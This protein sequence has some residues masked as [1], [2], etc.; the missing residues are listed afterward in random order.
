MSSV[1]TEK[2]IL[3]GILHVPEFQSKVYPHL[4]KELFE[5]DEVGQTFDL[6]K[7]YYDKFESLP[8]KE[9]L[10]VELENHKGL[11]EEGF[12]N[13]CSLLTHIYSEPVV[14]GIRKQN[15]DW[16]LKTSEKHLLQRSCFNAV[17]EA[18]NVVDGKD[19]KRSLES[20]P[21]LLK[22]AV[23]VS[24]DTEIGHDYIEDFM[25]RYEFYH[26][27]QERIPF[28][29]SM[30]NHVTGGG[31][32][33][34]AIYI[35][36]ASTGVGKS[37]FLTD[38]ASYLLT[39]G[40]N[41][42]YVTLEMA[43]FRL[44]ERVDAKLFDMTINDLPSLDLDGFQNKIQQLKEKK[45]GKIIFKEYPTGS[46]NAN[47][48]E[49]LLT[50]LKNKKNF[51]PDVLMVDYLNLMNSYRAPSG[52]NSYTV[53]KLVTEEL[54]GLAMKHNCLLCSPIQGNRSTQGS[55]E[56]ELAD[57]ADSAGIAMGADCMFALLSTP[58]LEELGH[59]RMK[60]LKNR[61]GSLYSPNSWLCGI[62]RAKMTL[63]DVD[64]P[65]KLTPQP[66]P[67][68]EIA[69]LDDDDVFRKPSLDKDKKKGMKFE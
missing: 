61:F 15:M 4:K 34:R 30:M 56:F 29:L 40:Y 22:E 20:L 57:V 54:R 65:N 8:T 17:I 69:D 28:S 62:N 66:L 3:A 39:E 67:K 53:M 47:H 21:D 43:D 25:K 11:T 18:F 31:G 16:M 37:L 60:L 48:L 35:P 64:L 12:Q 14:L 49:H 13:V 46:I 50:E 6:I 44:G 10:E 45:L 27:V 5:T 58:E 42:L 23:N 7:K 9:S 68:D 2:L 63:Y 32:V 41:V 19:K 33:R 51:K 24:F 38:W 55:G 1:V 26:D 59:I 52:A 36:A